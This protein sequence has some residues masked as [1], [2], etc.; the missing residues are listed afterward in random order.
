MTGGARLRIATTS[1]TSRCHLLAALRSLLCLPYCLRCPGI[2]GKINTDLLSCILHEDIEL[3]D[4]LVKNWDKIG[5]SLCD[6]LAKPLLPCFLGLFC[7][8]QDNAYE[9]QDGI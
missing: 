8:L 9:I 6:R 1:G 4:C 3:I 5:L 2:W 7:S